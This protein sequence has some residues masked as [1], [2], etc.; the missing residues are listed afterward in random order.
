MTLGLLCFVLFFLI[1]LILSTG[2]PFAL[3]IPSWPSSQIAPILIK[4]QVTWPVAQNYCRENHLD[5]F[6]IKTPNDQAQL[7][8][9]MN[10]HNEIG[11]VWTGLY[12][13][14]DSWYWSYNH[15][16][17]KNISLRN[18]SPGQPDNG[19]GEAV[20]GIIDNAGFW[21]AY[22]CSASV[23]YICYDGE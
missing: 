20:C 16:P 22:S 14:L 4:Q 9:E 3:S 8:R 11:P 21:W 23:S 13:D 18:W 5:L 19:N 6:T 15:L 10:N 2:I 7:I 1:F 12:N 17:L